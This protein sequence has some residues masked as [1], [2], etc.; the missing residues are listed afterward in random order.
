V[1]QVASSNSTQY[2]LLA[3]GEVYAW[4]LGAYG[5]LGDGGTTDSP[6]TPVQ[7][8]FPAGV[9]ISSLPTDAMPFDTG[10]AV[11]TE[12]NAWGWGLN[13]SGQLCLGNTTE[14]T[15]PVELPLTSVT[16]LAG[17]GDHALFDTNGDVDACGDNS[18]GDLGTGASGA[19][20]TPV[21]VQGLQGVA[22]TA[23]VASFNDSGALLADGTYEDWGFNGQGQLGDGDLGQSSD[24]PVA[25][26]LP[27][28]VTRAVEGGSYS[29]NG[30]TLVMLSN[31]ALYA[32][33]DDQ[34]GQLG[35]GQTTTEPS[36]VE[37]YPPPGVIYVLLATG[38]TTSYAVSTT[39][40]V[41]AWGGG[42]YGQIGH[43]RK[44][45]MQ[46]RPLRVETHVSMISATAY[47]V[48]TG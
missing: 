41:F 8:Q 42:R 30:Q 48:V 20:S 29:D 47:D 7:V 11:D 10:L 36:P 23:L 5:Q 33:G 21:P 15:T 35:D 43:G 2:A 12:G 44:E 28:G 40:H 4:G 39:A 34:Y 24:V 14:Y 31:G 13:S 26:S 38:G 1:V 19:S 6:T 46:F 22:V 18:Y 16:A 3:D 37:F 17:A 27:D 32:W 9:T 25:V 45:A